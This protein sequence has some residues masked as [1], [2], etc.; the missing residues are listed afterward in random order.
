LIRSRA[1]STDDLTGVIDGV[2][3]A[4]G[5]PKGAQVHH[6]AAN[7]KKR[8]VIPCAGSG[9][10]NHGSEAVNSA[11]LTCLAS[12]RA[13]VEHHLPIEEEGVKGPTGRR[14]I[15]HD[16]TRIVQATSFAQIAAECAQVN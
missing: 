11:G 1:R 3:P 15:A 8:M 5:P 12:E 14:G 7:Q 10:S 9:L 13:E 4:I 2:R 6:H 16:L